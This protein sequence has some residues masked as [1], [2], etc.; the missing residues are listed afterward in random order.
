MTSEVSLLT[1]VRPAAV[2]GSF[3]PSDPTALRES[4]GR[5]LEDANGNG[6]PKAL[7]APHAGYAYS[8]PVAASAYATLIP[9]RDRLSRVVLFG[10]AHRVP[11]K[12]IAASSA[13]SFRTPLGDVP[14]DV[15]SVES[16]V[17]L[18]QVAY[19]DVAHRSEHCLEVQLP[20]L[21]LVL[22]QFRIVP[23]V[24]GDVSQGHV[25][26]V[27]D[28]LWSGPETLVVVSSDLSHFHDHATASRIDRETADLIEA[29]RGG[30][31]SGRR[32]CGVEAIRGL[33]ECATARGLSVKTLDLKDSSQT[34]GDP[35][36][37]V[38]YGAFLVS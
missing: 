28:V 10:P 11:V 14:V 17:R 32:A 33:L 13:G 2:A 6:E 12:G 30:E 26:E 7:I 15:E 1:S 27:M 37:V 24:V 3:Y 18:A 9:V 21:Q 19:S 20:F 22:P 25:A 16:A 35:S 31:L 34:A 36:R 8:G 38:G 29:G 23:F 4:V 5:L